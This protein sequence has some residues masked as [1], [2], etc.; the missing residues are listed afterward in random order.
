MNGDEAPTAAEIAELVNRL[1]HI[2]CGGTDLDTT[3]RDEALADKRGL[4]ARIEAT[5]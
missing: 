4:L 3:V 2:Q 5:R 1:R